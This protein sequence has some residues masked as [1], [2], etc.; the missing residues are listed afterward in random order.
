MWERH[1]EN[2]KIAAAVGDETYDAACAEDDPKANDHYKQMQALK[3]MCIK[4]LQG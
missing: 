3:V 1:Q 2:I 4:Q